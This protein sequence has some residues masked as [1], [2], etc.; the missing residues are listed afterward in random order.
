MA[1]IQG[2]QTFVK[3]GKETTW[4][5]AVSA[6]VSSRVT[7]TALLRQQQRNQNT[8]LSTGDAGYSQ[9]FYDGFEETG[10]SIEFPVY[11]EG[12]GIWIEAA[13]GSS[14]TDSSGAPTYVHTYTPALAQPSL[15]IIN[16]R[17]SGSSEKFYGMIVS[18]ISITCEAGG[19]MMASVDLI[20]KSAD[21]R[22]GS[23][24]PS[25]GTGR[26][27]LHFEAAQ[28][29]FNATNYDLRSM[30]LTIDNK[31]SRRNLLG[32]KLTAEPTTDD[33]REVTLQCVMD[34]E[35]ATENNLYNESLGGTQGTVTLSFTNS[36]SDIF[37]VQLYNAVIL[38]Y[39]DAINSIGRVE[40]TV[41]FQGYSD[42]SNPSVKITITNQQ[43]SAIAN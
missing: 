23:I 24:S 2:R 10:G 4:G 34:V 22:T 20:G 12:S 41:T 37:K 6:T 35:S 15:S 5:T 25:F 43:N 40:R 28:I 1:V 7:S 17:G 9:G 26:Q 33:L 21:A 8:F 11:Y 14:S 39:D 16:Q 19:E 27:V 32:S 30:N 13:L 42:S 18:T 3:V 31:T 29:D 36:D 38:E